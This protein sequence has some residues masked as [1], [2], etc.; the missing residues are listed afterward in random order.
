MHD[1]ATREIARISSLWRYPVK[2]MQGEKVSEVK[3]DPSGVA[4]DRAYGVFRHE[5]GTILSAKREGR[6][7]E[8]AAELRS[9]VLVVILPSREELHQGSRLDDELS[10]WLGY[11]VSLVA[12]TT[13]GVPTFESPEDFER[14]DSRVVSWEGTSGRFV[15]ES[16]LHL[17]TSSE[18][19][20]LSG[21]RPDLQWDVR[22]FRPNIVVDDVEGGLDTSSLRRIQLGEVEIEIVKPCSRC[23]MTTR[24]QPGGLDRQLDVLRH[25]SRFHDGDVG[26]R[27]RVVHSGVVREGDEVRSLG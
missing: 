13:F 22:R 11:P 2:S 9:G 24:P 15:D 14:D 6:L 12:A 10:S 25:V 23:V 19:A 3:F 16:A 17:L 26:A 1:D 27:A 18:I 21:E 20:S 5:S 8:A 7:L 4:G